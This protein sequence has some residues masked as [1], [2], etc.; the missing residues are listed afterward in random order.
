MRSRINCTISKGRTQ[1]NG[2]RPVVI[3]YI[4]CLCRSVGMLDELRNAE[5]SGVIIRI[6]TEVLQTFLAHTLSVRSAC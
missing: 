5:R 3:G 6:A 1:D 2:F 4:A